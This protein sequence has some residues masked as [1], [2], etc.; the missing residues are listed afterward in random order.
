MLEEKPMDASVPLD[1]VHWTIYGKGSQRVANRC[2]LTEG[3]L[4]DVKNN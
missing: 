1:L 4:L 3:V 2:F